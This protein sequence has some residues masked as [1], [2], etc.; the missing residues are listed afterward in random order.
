LTAKDAP[1][2]DPANSRCLPRC[3]AGVTTRDTS[4]Q[5]DLLKT[6]KP[7]EKTQHP[8]AAY[9]IEQQFKLMAFL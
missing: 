8:V 1:G 9:G 6:T 2:Y 3:K 4:P 7:P 5:L